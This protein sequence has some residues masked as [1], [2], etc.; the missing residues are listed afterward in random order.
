MTVRI[1]ILALIGPFC[2]LADRAVGRWITVDAPERKPAYEYGAPPGTAWFLKNA[3]TG[4]TI[5]RA[6]WTLTA[7][8]AFDAYV[9][10]RKVNGFLEP[11]FTYGPKRRHLFSY[12]VTAACR[13]EIGTTNV[14]AVAV[15]PSWWSD[16]VTWRY[17]TRPGCCGRIEIDCADGTRTEVM[18]DASWL[19]AFTG[20][21]VQTGIYDGEDFDARADESF[22]E[23]GRACAAFRP[24]VETAYAG[25]MTPSPGVRVHLR[26]DLAR[27]PVHAYV[28]RG[29]QDADGTNAFGR[30][31]VRRVWTPSKALTLAPGETLVADFGQNCSAVPEFRF[32]APRGTRLTYRPAEMLNDGDGRTV[33]GCDGPGGSVYRANLRKARA[34]GN[35]VFAGTGHECYRPRFTFY[36][37]RYLSVTVEGGAV[38]LERLTSVPVTSIAREDEVGTLETGHKGLN[39]LVANARWG[40]LSNYLSVPTDCP[41]R[42][43]RLGW[44]ADTAVFAPAACWFARVDGF[45]EKWLGDLRDSCRTPGVYPSVAP[46]VAVVDCPMKF[47]WT[48][49][50]I[51]VPFILWRRYGKK[52]VIDA[53]WRDMEAYLAEVE[54]TRFQ[55]PLENFQ[56][57]DWLS[58]EAFESLSGDKNRDPEGFVAWWNYLGG[59]YWLSDA[60]RMA[61]M[62]EATGRSAASSRW[63]ASAS[64][65]RAYVRE[66]FLTADGDLH[67]RFRSMQTAHLFAL[68]CGLLESAARARACRRLDEN[69]RARENRPATGFL[70]TSILLDVVGEWLGVTRAYDVLLQRACPGWLYTVDQGA[71]TM[72]ER[73]NSYTKADGFGPVA[74]N[75]FNHYAYGCVAD[76]LFTTMAGIRPD[77][78]EPGWRRF[79]I[80]P[81]PDR[82]IG[83]AAATFRSPVGMIASAWRYRADGTCRFTFTVPAGTVA[84]VR[85]PGGRSERCAAG[86][87]ERILSMMEKGEE[88]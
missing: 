81:N 44:T 86:T 77:P 88:R 80:A 2:G 16:Q 21:V 31:I 43:E 60:E 18:T 8:G 45:L 40:M 59:C 29:V 15:S 70:G 32:S 63:R 25:A 12:D 64:R 83:H 41:Q 50:G 61:E 46:R 56:F 71:T 67:P 84:T 65:A 24:S 11:G 55:T 28:W 42:D 26:T 14:F 39:R 51:H 52:D 66:N 36:G 27:E 54:R 38:R 49:A 37:Y 20:K 82:R 4:K 75:S 6:R 72:W 7:W 53:N 9:N 73:W 48:D 33:R 34:C 3:I 10:G 13:R 57:A 78:S 76:W 79:E 47:G 74:M 69:L 35:Y 58:F 23:N 17:G 1:C 19:S 30:V 68:K 62:A 87:Y 5:V 85:L 22:L